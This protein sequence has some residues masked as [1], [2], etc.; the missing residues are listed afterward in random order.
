VIALFV[1]VALACSN[2]TGPSVQAVAGTDA[3]MQLNTTEAGTTTN[4]LASGASIALTLNANGTTSGR[5][6]GQLDADLAG[7][8]SLNGNT[9]RLSQPADTFLR[10]MDLRVRGNTLVGDQTFG[11]TR[12]QLTLTKQ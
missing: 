4:Q 1:N 2:S 5:W 6:P 3:A 12:V 8:W 9:V 10:D 11:S 7:T